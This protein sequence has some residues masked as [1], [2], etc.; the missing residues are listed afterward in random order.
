MKYTKISLLLSL[1][2]LN[3]LAGI[4][5][6]GERIWD[7]LAQTEDI[8]ITTDSK[9]DIIALDFAGVFTALQEID[10]RVIEDVSKLDDIGIAT[11]DPFAF[12]TA[13]LSKLEITQSLIPPIESAT[14]SLDDCIGVAITQANVGTTGFSITTPGR[15]FLAENITFSPA[16]AIPAIEIDAD[17]VFLD[18]GGF[19]ITQGNSQLGVYGVE[20][21]GVHRNV[22][23]TNGTIRNTLG[24]GIFTNSGV[25]N[26]IL[27]NLA[28]L[29]AGIGPGGS[30]DLTDGMDLLGGNNY[31]IEN[32][33]CDNCQDEG[34]DINNI[35]Y[36]MVND[37]TFSTNRGVEGGI[38]FDLSASY[39]LV[40]NCLSTAN[41][42]SGFSFNANP[43]GHVFLNCQALANGQHGF[44]FGDGAN[45]TNSIILHSVATGNNLDGINIGKDSAIT[46]CVVAYNFSANNGRNGIRVENNGTDRN[47]FFRNTLIENGAT[48]I[49][50]VSSGAENSY[51]GNYAYSSTGANYNTSGGSTINST[52]VSTS[53][54]FSTQP[55]FWRNVSASP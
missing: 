43:L 37:C 30:G 21:L 45:A 27:R 53:S 13:M 38:V 14:D 9:L 2:S 54:A 1:V 18:L 41:D 22:V 40:I 8:A 31:I 52:A 48:N 25:N 4:P 11:L 50:E 7:I 39:F 10:N 51:L 5:T 47:F 36:G 44:N 26:V 16:S 32:V 29:N 42:N 15:Y 19:T 12:T 55:V 35:D 20:V 33:L 6:S 17:E 23:I 24:E 34:I 3:I 49:D 28:I 46:Q